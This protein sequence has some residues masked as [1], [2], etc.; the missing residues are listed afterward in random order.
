MAFHA[1]LKTLG[2]VQKISV[3]FKNNQ[4]FVGKMVVAS[5]LCRGISC[6]EFVML[7]Y[8]IPTALRLLRRVSCMAF[9]MPGV[10]IPKKESLLNQAF[11]LSG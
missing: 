11:M 10:M 5:Y 8:I 3:P 9:I 2:L 1:L 4:G 7:G 6:F